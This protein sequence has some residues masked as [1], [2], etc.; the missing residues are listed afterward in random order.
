M[1]KLPQESADHPAN[2]NF[3]LNLPDRCRM[4]AGCVLKGCSIGGWPSD[5]L[6]ESIPG[7]PHGD[8]AIDFAL[9]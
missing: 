5:F 2:F 1:A 3:K 8:P 6:Q 7:S 4:S 9:L